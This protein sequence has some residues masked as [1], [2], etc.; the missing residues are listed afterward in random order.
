MD[1]KVDLTAI[2]V[3]SVV[4][5]TSAVIVG[6]VFYFIHRSRELRQQTIR[7]LLEKGQPVP[8]A[9]LADEPAKQPGND[10][11]SGVKAVFIGIG[12]SL[13]FYFV[14]RD[15]WPVGLIAGFVGLGHIAAWALTGRN[16]QDATPAQ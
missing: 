6:M 2:V 8:A 14:H 10:L 3:V 15:L 9:L 5:L 13:F 4:F 7:L 1:V 12:L 11:S 16:Q